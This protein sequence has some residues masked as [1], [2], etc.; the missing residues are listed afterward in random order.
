MTRDNR[1]GDDAWDQGRGGFRM[2]SDLT[3]S[4]SVTLQGDL[5]YGH[6]GQFNTEISSF[7]PLARNNF[8]DDVEV[9]GGNLLG[10][11][12]HRFSETAGTSLQMYY[13]RTDRLGRTIR[14]ARDTF[15]LDFQNDFALTDWNSVTWGTGYRVTRDRTHGTPTSAFLVPDT[16][17]GQL[18][19]A[20]LQNESV[21]VKDLLRFIVGSKFEWNNYTGFE[22]QPSARAVLTPFESHTFW[23][24][25]SRAVRTPSRADTNVVL[26]LGASSTTCPVQIPFPPFVMMLPCTTVQQIDATNS[27]GS[28]ALW[29]Y[30]L[31]WRWN[32]VRSFSVDVAAYYNDYQNLRTLE[33]VANPIDAS[34]FPVILAPIVKFSNKL[35]GQT[36]G[37]ELTTSWSPIDRWK[38][39]GNYSYFRANMD[40]DL[41]SFDPTTGPGIEK[42]SPTHQA[43]LRSLVDLPHGFEFDTGVYWVDHIEA[44]VVDTD[45]SN[46]WTL[47]VRL[48]WHVTDNL[49]LSVVGQNAQEAQ[50]DEFG[51][52]L[53][54]AGT[55]VERS[56]FG[57]VTVRY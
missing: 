49:E 3:D 38:L 45:I 10:R 22:I 29:A 35:D 34:G 18:V 21:V 20:F 54:S 39:I 51:G 42:G 9:R 40:P 24:A 31:G 27:F 32:P 26:S 14:E 2:D 30:E 17:T 47:N 19:N 52:G 48:G 56:V 57:Q 28:E 11:W 4:D 13:D 7:F 25:V 33:P 12:G 8:E 43:S 23:G 15:D 53:F 44:G 6:S 46:Y 1:K 37:A 55:D 50:H 36:Y 5:Y 41:D 16:R